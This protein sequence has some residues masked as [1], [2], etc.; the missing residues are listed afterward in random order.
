M[1]EVVDLVGIRFERWVVMGRA[2]TR[3]KS[4]SIRYTCRCDC[5]IIKDVDSNS[6]K[7]GRSKSCGCFNIDQM[8][9]N[10]P[11]L[12]HGHRCGQTKSSEYIAWTNMIQR[13]TNSRNREYKYYGARGIKVCQEWLSFDIFLND[14][15][16]KPSQS[17]S[18]DRIDNNGNYELSNCR[19]ATAKQQANNRRSRGS[20][21]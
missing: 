9:A 3:T 18:I 10:P 12:R 21:I 5:G 17:L 8:I 7:R 14:M 1:K 19:W 6:L 13:C 2:K 20:V 15:G 11:R 4:G 16:Y